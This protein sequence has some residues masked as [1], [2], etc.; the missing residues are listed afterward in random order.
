MRLYS[1][2]ESSKEID[3]FIKGMHRYIQLGVHVKGFFSKKYNRFQREITQVVEFYVDDDANEAKVNI[4]YERDLVGNESYSNPTSHLI[5]YMA[6]QGVMMRED[7]FIPKESEV[8]DG[9][10]IDNKDKVEVNNIKDI[11]KEPETVKK[12]EENPTKEE[13]KLK[14]EMPSNVSEE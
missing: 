9:N 10:S 1:L 13:E 7:P 2:L 11:K 5:D 12:I 8:K 6:A 3:Q 4:L 14:I